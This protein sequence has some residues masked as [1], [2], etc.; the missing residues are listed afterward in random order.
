MIATYRVPG[1]A[2][3]LA[4]IFYVEANLICLN[5]FDLTLTLSG[6]AGVILS[7]GMAVDANVIIYTRI[8]EEITAGNSV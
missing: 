3:A 4:L 8:K 1:I 7:I 5:G 2:A 6:S